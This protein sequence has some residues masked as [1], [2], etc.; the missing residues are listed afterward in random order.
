MKR[1]LFSKY[2]VIVLLLWG[3]VACSDISQPQA[4]DT[5]IAAI[6]RHYIQIEGLGKLSYLMVGEQGADR[7]IFVHGTPGDANNWVDFLLNPLAGFE[8]I[9]IDRPGFGESTPEQ[10]VV[11]LEMQ[12][13]LIHALRAPDR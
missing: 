11:S 7:I 9:A 10:A 8:F 6:D 2:T 4:S 13:E 5:D 12:A 3:L 1:D